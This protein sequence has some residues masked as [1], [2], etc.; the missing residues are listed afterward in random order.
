MDY[1]IV[2]VLL[3]CFNDFRVVLL[4]EDAVD[5]RTLKKENQLLCKARFEESFVNFLDADCPANNQTYSIK[6]GSVEE[7]K[8]SFIMIFD[9]LNDV[10]DIR[11]VQVL[12]EPD[13]VYEDLTSTT[14]SQIIN[15][16]ES[17]M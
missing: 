4:A 5:F 17:L 14:L 8:V 7:V 3:E 11:N 2:E 12:V 10:W 16:L 15:Y 6:I 1:E 13:G 9:I